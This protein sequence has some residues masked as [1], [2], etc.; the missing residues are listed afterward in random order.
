MKSLLVIFSTKK[1][2]LVAL[3][4]WKSFGI[5]SMQNMQ[6]KNNQPVLALIECKSN[7]LQIDCDTLL[8]TR[9]WQVRV[10]LCVSDVEILKCFVYL[11]FRIE[12]FDLNQSHFEIDCFKN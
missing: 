4:I 9:N 6:V 1:S 11:K 3:L 7:L 5:Q 10:A 12:N 8:G 2:N